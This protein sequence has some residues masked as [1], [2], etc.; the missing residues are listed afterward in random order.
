MADHVFTPDQIVTLPPGRYRLLAEVEVT[1]DKKLITGRRVAIPRCTCGRLR[2]MSDTTCRSCG[3]T[4]VQSVLDKVR[5]FE[6]DTSG[7]QHG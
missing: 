7:G 1:E 4:Q 6:A 2:A 3:R 5:E